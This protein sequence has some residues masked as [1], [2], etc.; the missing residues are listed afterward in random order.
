MASEHQNY[1]TERE[2]K[3]RQQTNYKARAR[4]SKAPRVGC[5]QNTR[6]LSEMRQRTDKGSA[7]HNP[8]QAANMNPRVS[9]KR[10]QNTHHQVPSARDLLWCNDHNLWVFQMNRSLA[11]TTIVNDLP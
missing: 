7:N 5:M 4:S 8:P 9:A 11:L 3:E 10:I 6:Q 1:N 2:A